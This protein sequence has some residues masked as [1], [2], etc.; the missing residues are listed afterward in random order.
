[1]FMDCPRSRP[2]P[3]RLC[4]KRVQ[5]AHGSGLRNGFAQTLVEIELLHR[6][7]PARHKLDRAI[8]LE[9]ELNQN[10]RP[11]DDAFQKLRELRGIG[12]AVLKVDV[13]DEWLLQFELLEG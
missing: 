9:P 3:R 10:L 7:D 11:R 1:M 12:L 5:F 8:H 4:L 6:T 2:N 13:P